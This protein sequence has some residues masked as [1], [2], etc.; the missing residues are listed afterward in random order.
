MTL[1]ARVSRLDD[2]S[3]ELIQALEKLEIENS[4]GTLNQ[5]EQMD[6]LADLRRAMVAKDL[7]PMKKRG[8][9]TLLLSL[10]LGGGAA[11]IPPSVPNQLG[12]QLG[13][14]GAAVLCLAIS[15]WSFIRFFKRRQRDEAWLGTME[16][17]AAKGGSI[18]DVE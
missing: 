12:V 7:S 11:F 8:R 18:F 3:G 15:I 14:L 16:A 4:R 9:V 2:Y 5:D 13:A 6:F 17:A 10:V 1:Q